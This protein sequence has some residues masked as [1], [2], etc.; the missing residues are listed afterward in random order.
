MLPGKIDD[1]V[2]SAVS[3]VNASGGKLTDEQIIKI[4][5]ISIKEALKCVEEDERNKASIAVRNLKGLY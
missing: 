5:K 4:I 1:V 2:D 3:T